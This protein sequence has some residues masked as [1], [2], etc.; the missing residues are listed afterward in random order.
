[1][2][3]GTPPPSSYS[4]ATNNLSFFPRCDPTRRLARA[5]RQMRHARQLRLRNKRRKRRQSGYGHRPGREPER[6]A[7]GCACPSG[8]H[9]A[10]AP[11]C[12]RREKRHRGRTALIRRSGSRDRKPPYGPRAPRRRRKHRTS[13]WA[14][15]TSALSEA[16]HRQAMKGDGPGQHASAGSPQPGGLGVD[17]DFPHERPVEQTKWSALGTRQA[18][19]P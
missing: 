19:T 3:D 10:P 12:R 1:M 4:A 2:P 6:R 5:P 8:A 15:Q 17:D 14:S 13:P 9:G 16:S 18:L 11:R 7:A